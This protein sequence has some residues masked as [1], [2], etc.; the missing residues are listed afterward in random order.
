MRGGLIKIK[1]KSKFAEIVNDIQTY[2][3]SILDNYK[4]EIYLPNN[5]DIPY[6]SGNLSDTAA[7]N[8][9]FEQLRLVNMINPKDI[10]VYIQ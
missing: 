8:D 9:C 3:N 7:I 5:N 6:Y 10:I 2:I 4:I 1:E